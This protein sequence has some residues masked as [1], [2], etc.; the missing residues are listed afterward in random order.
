VTLRRKER[1]Q[2]VE[3]SR[4]RLINR[5]VERGAGFSIE[6]V[7]AAFEAA[8]DI[9][10]RENNLRARWNGPRRTQYRFLVWIGECGRQM[11]RLAAQHVYRCNPVRPAC[12]AYDGRGGRYAMAVADQIKLWQGRAG[13]VPAP[14]PARSARMRPLR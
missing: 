9:S 1:S 13:V 6:I 14:R 12:E 2:L 3:V 11:P 10:S 5:P 8:I 4:D 7:E